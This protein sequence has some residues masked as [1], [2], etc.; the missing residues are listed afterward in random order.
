MSRGIVVLA[1]DTIGSDYIMQACLLAMSFRKTNPEENISVITNDKI[2]DNYKQLFDKIIP[3]PFNDDASESLWKIENRWK[4]YHATPYDET[5]V[6]DTDMIILDNIGY[7]WNLLSNYQL[8]FTSQVYTYRGEKVVDDYYRKTFV[9]NN[10]PNLYSGLH[11]FKKCEFAHEFYTWLEVINNNW[12]R[13]YNDYLPEETPIRN[14]VD[15]N[16]ALTAKILD[17]TDKITN[18]SVDFVTFTHMKSKIQNWQHSKTLWMESVAPYISDNINIKIGNYL[19]HGI[20]HYTEDNFVTE[21]LEQ[22][23]RR[24]LDV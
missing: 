24:Y 19:Q 4:I 22:L 6:L 16:A 5:I 3:I 7:M 23:Y 18:N 17:C 8:F 21:K 2:P 12:Q 1:Q 13:F 20:F 9:A 11:Y 10:L 14:S 15:V